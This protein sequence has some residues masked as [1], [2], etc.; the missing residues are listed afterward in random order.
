MVG[1]PGSEKESRGSVYVLFLKDD[2]SLDSFVK[3]D[4]VHPGD[5]FGSALAPIGDIDSDGTLEVAMSF[6][7]GGG[8]DSLEGEGGPDVLDG[9]GANDL[10]MGGAGDDRYEVLR[11]VLWDNHK[12]SSMAGMTR[13]LMNFLPEDKRP[14]EV[15]GFNLGRLKAAYQV[16]VDA[17]YSWATP[18]VDAAGNQIEQPV[19]AMAGHEGSP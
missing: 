11:W 7:A 15:I 12:L 18:P 10:L 6:L 1:A 5:L 13:F 16:L 3:I 14:A 2:L 17:G 8:N 19:S 9:R 4:D